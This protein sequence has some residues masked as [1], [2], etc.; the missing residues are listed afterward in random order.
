MMSPTVFASI[1]AAAIIVCVLAILVL[2]YLL[3]RVQHESLLQR[4]VDPQAS[5]VAR[6]FGVVGTAPMI[7]TM[8]RSG[9]AIE[10]MVDTEGESGRLMMQAGWR[11]AKARLFWYAFQA[12][13]PVFM[14]AG[15]AAFWTFSESPKRAQ[16]GLLLLIVAAILSFLAPRW[17][18]RAAASRRRERVQ[19]EVPLFIHLLVLLFE[20]GLS[21]RQAL[22][23]IVRESGGVL[24]ELGYEFDLAM[25]QVDAGGEL[26]EALKALGDMLAVEDL[27]TVLGVLRQVDRY[28]GELREPLLETLQ[29][30]EERRGFELRE[31]VNQLS[32]RM[33]VVMVMFF[34]PGLLIFVAGPAFLAIVTALKG[35]NGH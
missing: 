16:L 25:R 14:F 15:V 11:S 30:I 2:G 21:T 35:M 5:A 17:V 10:Q 7:E 34:F 4:R 8:A 23:S 6:D 13:L 26:G 29:V 32:G 27:T 12:V 3:L 19:R 24:P 31:K 28:G 1:V 9:K 33:T 22:S 20:S 18:L